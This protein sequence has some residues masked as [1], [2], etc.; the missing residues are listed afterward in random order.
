M[1]SGYKMVIKCYTKVTVCKC[2]MCV[3]DIRPFRRLDHWRIPRRPSWRLTPLVVRPFEPPVVLVVPPARP[4]VALV[5]PLVP[6]FASPLPFFAELV[7]S[8]V[9]TLLLLAPWPC[10]PC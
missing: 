4:F 2:D 10:S 6:L 9:P 7:A 3:V 5:A 8:L 1:F